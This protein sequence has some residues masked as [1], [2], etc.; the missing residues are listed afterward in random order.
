MSTLPDKYPQLLSF[1]KGKVRLAKQQAALSVNR[2]MLSVYW[3]IG[4]TIGEQQKSEGWGSKVIDQ[5]SKDLSSEFPDMKGF[6]PR[7][8]LY[9][10]QFAEA[11]TIT[12]PLVVNLQ[13]GDF[14]TIEFTQPQVA[15]IPWTHHS[16]INHW[17]K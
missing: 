15:Q 3:L 17:K 13:S 8:L 16:F 14:Q 7:N 11:Y 12:Q 4:K 1:L 6:S 2:E 9:M 5:L 10:R